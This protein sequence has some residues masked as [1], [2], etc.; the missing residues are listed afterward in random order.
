MASCEIILDV[1]NYKEIPA[2]PSDAEAKAN[3]DAW[4]L[5]QKREYDLAKAGNVTKKQFF[6]GVRWF[7]E[8][9][10]NFNDIKPEA[11]GNETLKQEGLKIVD[12]TPALTNAEKARFLSVAGL[13]IA[14]SQL[15]ALNGKTSAMLSLA[16]GDEKDESTPSFP[17]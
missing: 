13:L 14:D 9:Q 1:A 10:L 2:L 11:A 8:K 4:F 12:G 6:L 3:G 5:Q 17:V 16:A 15:D 7:L